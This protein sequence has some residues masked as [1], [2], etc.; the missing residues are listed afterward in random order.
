MDRELGRAP[1]LQKEGNAGEGTGE[2]EWF[3]AAEG[4]PTAPGSDDMQ[5]GKVTSAKKKRKEM[6]I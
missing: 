4:P 3:S 6:L 5:Q 2:R 1:G